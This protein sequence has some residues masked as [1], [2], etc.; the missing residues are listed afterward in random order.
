MLWFELN[1]SMALPIV[2]MLKWVVRR[3]SRKIDT[4][5]Q[6]LRLGS[7]TKSLILHG[8]LR[9]DSKLCLDL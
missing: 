5:C 1:N 2:E 6:T 9:V 8:Y 4:F 3:L 7:N